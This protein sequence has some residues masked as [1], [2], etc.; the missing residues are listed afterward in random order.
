MRRKALYSSNA[1]SKA[2]LGTL[3]KQFL[4]NSKVSVQSLRISV[5]E[6]K[7]VASTGMCY[8]DLRVFE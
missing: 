2:A 7:P 8:N 6:R 3:T 4:D 1:F 5:L